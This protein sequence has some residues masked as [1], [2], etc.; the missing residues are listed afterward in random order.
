MG[1]ADGACRSLGHAEVLHFSGVDEFLDGTRHVLDGDVRINP[2]LVVE[3][4]G[5]HS[6][7][8]Q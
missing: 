1:P 4:Q 2:V 3:I 5:V 8:L 6:Q 7:P